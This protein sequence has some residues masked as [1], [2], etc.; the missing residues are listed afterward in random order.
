MTYGE[1]SAKL[2]KLSDIS[3]YKEWS[4]L[5]KNHF[6]R[7]KSW[8]IVSGTEKKPRDVEKLGSFEEISG[9]AYVDLVSALKGELRQLA[10]SCDTVTDAWKKI[11]EVCIVSDHVLIQQLEDQILASEF[12]GSMIQLLTRLDTLYS[13]L[14]T[15]GVSVSDDLKTTRLLKL[16]PKSYSEV[17]ITIKISPDYKDDNVFNYGK[18]TKY[19]KTRAAAEGDFGVTTSGSTVKVKE[20]FPKK[21]TIKKGSHKRAHQDGGCFCCGSKDHVKSDNLCC[22][23]CKEEGHTI[24][25][26]PVLKKKQQQKKIKKSQKSKP[27]ADSDD[28]SIPDKVLTRMKGKMARHVKTKQSKKLL[29]S[30]RLQWL[31]DSGASGHASGCL[32]ILR[33]IRKL[34]NKT[35]IE[36]MTSFV[37][38]EK[39]GDFRGQ[40]PSGEPLVLENVAYEESFRDSFILSTSALTDEDWTFQMNKFECKAFN[41]EGNLVFVAQKNPEDRLYYLETDFIK[42][43]SAIKALKGRSTEEG[44]LWHRRLNHRGISTIQLMKENN[45]VDGLENADLGDNLN[46]DI[47]PQTKITSRPIAKTTETHLQKIT[48]PFQCI[49]VDLIGKLPVGG[50]TLFSFIS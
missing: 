6:M 15:A 2:P 23:Y 18:V 27:R 30:Q 43:R 31:I 47:C 26:C 50:T 16:L 35:V 33:N 38:I 10:L 37:L 29:K 46:C 32:D 20:E 12:R 28:E 22:R 45:V 11:A 42:N 17:V 39:E 41:P 14:E 36:T 44:L 3:K 34:K 9:G 4:N 7:T 48:K 21:E 8:R 49:H 19:L 24:D 5:L 40:L 25:E 1:K 13:R